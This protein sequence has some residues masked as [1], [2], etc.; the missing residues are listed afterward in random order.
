MIGTM[1]HSFQLRLSSFIV[2]CCVSLSVLGQSNSKD[3]MAQLDFMVGEWIGTSTVYDDGKLSKQGSAYEEISFDLDSTLIVIKLNSEFL[4]L[5]TIIRYDEDEQT[6][7]YYPFSKRG[8]NRYPAS[9]QDGQLVVQPSNT[10]RFIFGRTTEGGFQEYGE[11]LIDGEW[12][13]YF[14][15]TFKNS[16]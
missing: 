4:Q 7:Y 15:D 5:H 8:T 14:E 1:M 6:Y 11:Q 2:L 10:K 9:Y 13:K 16:Q 12:V 3:K